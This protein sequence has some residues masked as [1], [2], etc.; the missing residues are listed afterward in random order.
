MDLRGPYG[1]KGGY[2]ES[3][4][5]GAS[6]RCTLREHDTRLRVGRGGAK[7]ETEASVQALTLL[8]TRSQSDRPP[9]LV[10]DGWGEHR[11]ALVE[12]YGKVP[13]YAGRGRLPTRKQPQPDWQPMQV[14]KPRENG[15]VKG[16]QTRVM[17][18][19][20]QAVLTVLGKPTAYVERTHLTSRH[21]NSRLARKTLGFSKKVEMFIAACIWEDGGGQPCAPG[22][23][24]ADRS[25]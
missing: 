16:A 3:D 14:V 11:E 4:E 20:A 2:P 6:W 9:A 8:K 18:G 24:S 25:Q 15:R 22:Q 10:S 7:T 12:V 17:N 21:M 5:A 1:E 19:A 13:P 23:I